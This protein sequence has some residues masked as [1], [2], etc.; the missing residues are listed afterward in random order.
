MTEARLRWVPV[1]IPLPEPGGTERF[2]VD[3]LELLLCNT[4]GTPRVVQDEC[5]HVHTSLRGGLLKGTILECPMHG[6]QLDL[7]DGSPVRM[8]IRR[9]ACVYPVRAA[10]DGWQVGLPSE[11]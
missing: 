6:G 7:R 9:A 1:P 3:A 4:G 11:T 2:V 10:G 5:P 8:P